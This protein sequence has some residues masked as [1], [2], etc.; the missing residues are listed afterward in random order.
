M[1][2]SSASDS[3][4]GYH[5]AKSETSGARPGMAVEMPALQISSLPSALFICCAFSECSH[6][7]HRSTIAASPA[8]SSFT[9]ASSAISTAEDL[10][11]TCSSTCA[12]ESEITQFRPLST[13]SGSAPTASTASY[14][15]GG[16][17]PS[18]LYTENCALSTCAGMT[19]ASALCA[20]SAKNANDSCNALPYQAAG[21][22]RISSFGSTTT[23]S[24]N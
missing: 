5:S 19:S 9:I 3:R 18:W 21:I 16:R 10:R 23:W 20:A 8:R 22:A 15:P 1:A 6:C 24:P 13:G 4:R 11:P 2:S 12:S 14:A 7:F 17:K